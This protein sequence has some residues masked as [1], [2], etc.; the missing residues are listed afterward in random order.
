MKM[1]EV[2]ERA[3]P[4]ARESAATRFAAGAVE[5]TGEPTRNV[6][7]GKLPP[8]S[9]TTAEPGNTCRV[10]RRVLKCLNTSKYV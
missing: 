2:S 1:I 10:T 4:A 6:T 7:K 9:S 3:S 8:L 5:A